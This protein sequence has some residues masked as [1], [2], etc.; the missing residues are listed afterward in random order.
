MFKYMKLG[1]FNYCNEQRYEVGSQ[2]V[3]IYREVWRYLI[4]YRVFRGRRYGKLKRILF[5]IKYKINLGWMIR[6]QQVVLKIN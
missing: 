6:R 5:F 3:L 1:E 4:E 2:K